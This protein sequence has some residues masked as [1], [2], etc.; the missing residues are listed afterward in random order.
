MKDLTLTIPAKNES[1]CLP[2]TL[3]EI[4]ELK[5][6][7]NITV[8]LKPEDTSTINSIKNF[9]V[10]II[11]QS[12]LGYGNALIEGLKSCTTKYFCIFNADGSFDP[13]ELKDMYFLISNKN[14]DLVFGSRYCIG[15]SSEDDTIVTKFGNFVFSKIGNIFFKL[16]ISD[17]L[18]TYVMG[19]VEKVSKLNLNSQDFSYCVELP[20]KSKRAKLKISDYPSHERKR[21]AGKK[22]VNEF[23]DGYKILT[24]MLILFFKKKI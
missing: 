12:G 3:Q 4:S 10:K 21:I 7:C 24:E 9:D 6:E 22:K 13:K 5:L 11:Y 23:R 19:D 8:I 15:G 14:Y 18:Y 20:I 17:I 2:K 16:K 1:K